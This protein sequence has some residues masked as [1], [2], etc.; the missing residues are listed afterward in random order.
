MILS[1]SLTSASLFHS[2]SFFFP[3]FFNLKFT[4]EVQRWVFPQTL[5]LAVISLSVHEQD[6][7]ADIEDDT[8]GDVRNLLTS[9]L[10]VNPPPSSF[11]P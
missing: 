1:D 4:L 10:Q 8:S 9:L 2:F 7:E 11:W 3:Y 5:G 6:L